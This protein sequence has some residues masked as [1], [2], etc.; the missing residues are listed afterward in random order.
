MLD[1]C[2]R[3]HTVD[4]IYKAVTI[5]NEMGIKTNIDFIFGLPH[6]T[7]EDIK[8][9][10]QV[11]KDLIKLGGRVH[12]H[13]FIP[14]PQTPF[15][16]EKVTKLDKSLKKKLQD[17]NYRGNLYGD[18]RKQEKLALKIS[19]YLKRNKPKTP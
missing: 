6:E 13:T 11:M 16:N 10:L 1:M 8:K 7:T 2:H 9:T 5:S 3:G 14:L 12:A 18:W 17:M 4:D 19:K 15:E